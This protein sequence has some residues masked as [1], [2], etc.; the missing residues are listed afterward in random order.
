MKTVEIDDESNSYD[1]LAREILKL[2]DKT[3][4][5]T[6]EDLH[7]GQTI[8]IL[9]E[10]TVQELGE[11][12]TAIAVER[13]DKEKELTEPSKAEAVDTIICALALYYSVGGRSEELPTIMHHKLL[14]WQK[15]ALRRQKGPLRK[16]VDYFTSPTKST[17]MDEVR[18]RM[19]AEDPH[20]TGGEQ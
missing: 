11:F 20:W 9:V 19:D 1:D 16:S 3:A 12:C 7:Y 15:R 5:V 10:H 8:S 2:L 6:L 17:M 4:A 18:E 13:G 14:K